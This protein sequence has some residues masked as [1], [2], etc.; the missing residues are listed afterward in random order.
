MSSSR[1]LRVM[2]W[3]SA[4]ASTSLV[5]LPVHVLI[6]RVR[7]HTR[8]STILTWS[9]DI[10]A[11][12][13]RHNHKKTDFSIPSPLALLFLSLLLADLLVRC[14]AG[15]QFVVGFK[16]VHT[17][18]SYFLQILRGWTIGRNMKLEALAFAV[19]LGLALG[20][21][22]SPVFNSGS[23]FSS[24]A[25]APQHEQT[26]DQYGSP[27]APVHS[28]PQ[29]SNPDSYGSPQ[30]P[31]QDSYG[32]PLAPA[33]SYTPSKA[34]Q[35]GD[36]YGSPNG[37]PIKSVVS[38]GSSGPISSAP[39][40]VP[41]QVGTQGYY[42]YYY[43][44]TNSQ[45][46]KPHH[47]SSSSYVSSQPSYHHPSSSNSGKDKGILGKIGIIAAVIIGLIILAGIVGFASF[48]ANP[49]GRSNNDMFG[50]DYSQ[51]TLEDL[52]TY[53]YDAVKLYRSLQ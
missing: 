29:S 11:P 52:T 44:V 34:T 27:N 33:T 36:S 39:S 23:S 4:A 48:T 8:G 10:V 50:F 7:V 19:V 24:S 3:A 40:S 13:T 21:K 17:R 2:K 22:P 49:L 16:G 25:S 43:P 35:A 47:T 31:A 28:S 53:V 30:A 41:G 32:S 6:D 18:P 38:T 42:Y 1:S 15:L 14:T 37:A 51:S 46:S 5:A 26:S 9:T 12:D 20:D 45:P